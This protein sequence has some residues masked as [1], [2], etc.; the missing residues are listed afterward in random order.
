MFREQVS[1]LRKHHPGL[2]PFVSQGVHFLRLETIDGNFDGF[3]FRQLG[4]QAQAGEV[5][6]LE[7]SWWGMKTRDYI[8]PIRGTGVYDEKNTG[9]IG[10]GPKEVLVVPES[11]RLIPQVS[12][13]T[14]GSSH[15]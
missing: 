14:T 2:D 11:P 8:A 5:V 1:T 3:I 4:D 12:L 6:A 13:A 15:S 10:I 9:I 7:Q